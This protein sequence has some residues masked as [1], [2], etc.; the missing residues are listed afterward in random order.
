M[1]D[2]E[3]IILENVSSILKQNFENIYIIEEYTEG[4]PVNFP[5]VLIYQSSNIVNEKYSTFDHLENVVTEVYT[6]EIFSKLESGRRQEIKEIIDSVNNVMGSYGY[7]R[8]FNEPVETK[9]KSVSKT[10]VKYKKDKLTGG[11]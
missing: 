2:Q 4:L 7:I 1:I 9:D 3:L 11:K 6:C 5:C 10:V 8:S